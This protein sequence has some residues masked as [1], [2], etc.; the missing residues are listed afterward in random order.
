MNDGDVLEGE[1]EMM[2]LY[3][4]GHTAGDICIYLPA[5]K[6]LASGDLV[7]GADHQYGLVLSKPDEVCGGRMKDRIESLKKLLSLDVKTLLPG[8]GSPVIES[9]YDQVKIQLLETFRIEEGRD[10]AK[11]W[12]RM[13]E[14]LSEL[15]DTMGAI[16]CCEMALKTD[17]DCSEAKNMIARLHGENA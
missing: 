12:L 13:A 5:V 1:R 14:V 17:K 9:G 10:S 8:H 16:E 11:P 2:V 15:G 3:T 6:T 4:P 7:L